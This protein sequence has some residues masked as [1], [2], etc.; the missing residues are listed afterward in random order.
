MTDT[1]TTFQ[2]KLTLTL[3][4]VSDQA[5]NSVESLPNK[6]MLDDRML[7]AAPGP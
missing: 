4:I 2:M 7:R 1:D 5:G 6:V 3:N